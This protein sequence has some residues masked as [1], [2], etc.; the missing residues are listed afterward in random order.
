[1]TRWVPAAVSAVDLLPVGV[2]SKPITQGGTTATLTVTRRIVTPLSAVRGS[3]VAEILAPYA[4]AV[5]YQ[6]T[7]ALGLEKVTVAA[8]YG[9]YENLGTTFG[10]LPPDALSPPSPATGGTKSSGK[11]QPPPP[12]QFD[13]FS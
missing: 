3:V 9:T 12:Q 4:D 6:V 5:D 10:I 1:M 11:K 8:S 7:T 2:P 13:P